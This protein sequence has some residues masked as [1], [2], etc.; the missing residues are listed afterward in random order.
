MAN[1]TFATYQDAIDWLFSATDYEKM[2]RVRYNADTFDLARMTAL[3]RRLGPPHEGRRF[4]HIAGT[5][6]KGSTAT[7]VNE[8][9]R[10][11]GHRVGLYTS[12]HVT[13]MRERVRLNGEMISEDTLR[14]V[15]GRVRSAVE[16]VAAEPNRTAPTY[17]EI[18]T[19]VAL[20]YFRDT[21]ADAAVLEVGLGG[22]LDATNVVTPL[23]CGIT[24]ISIDHVAQLGHTLEE[25]A[26]E[27]AGIIKPGVPVVSAPQSAEAL[28]VVERVAADRGAP[29]WIVGR[30]IEIADFDHEAA[31]NGVGSRVTIRT[32]LR[33]YDDIRLA[34]AGRHQAVN[35]AVAVGL[36]ERAAE[37][38]LDWP[39]RALRDGL[40]AARPRA[41]VEVLGRR[42]TV[43][44]DGAHN[45]ASMH[46]LVEVLTDAV[47]HERLILVFASSADHDYAANL[48]CIL[49]LA[50][51]VILTTSSSPKSA[52]PADLAAALGATR[53]LPVELI[54]DASAA[55]DRA[56][57]LAGPDDLLCFTGSFYLAG[58]IHAWWR[59]R[60]P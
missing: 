3:L 31:G 50:D 47:P 16:A 9:L 56:L 37:R 51:H 17:F 8:V 33:Q 38:G 46:A 34:A 30:E 59:T 27:K 49:P 24:S 19:A 15:I 57:A 21:N 1:D 52:A 10:A 25:I 58:L 29:L 2:R 40:A 48:A 53:P 32:P 42:P 55:A 36:L 28:A 14:D 5:K 43:V 11:A 18:L 6:G 12:P 4:I 45:P 60:H 7:M 13:D 39:P 44:N 35:A 20:V 22:R 54:P 26:G 41:R 23:A